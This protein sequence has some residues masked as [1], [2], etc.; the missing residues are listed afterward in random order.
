MLQTI[1]SH[2]LAI[3]RSYHRYITQETEPVNDSPLERTNMF[4]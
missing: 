4:V 1:F 2:Y 3:H